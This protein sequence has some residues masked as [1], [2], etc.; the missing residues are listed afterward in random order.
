[1]SNIVFLKFPKRYFDAPAD[2]VAQLIHESGLLD[3]ISELEAKL[4]LM[5]DYM[6]ELR[7]I[8]D[9]AIER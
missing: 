5:R 4:S 7:V 9:A 1:M 8:A 6:M 3:I 2:E